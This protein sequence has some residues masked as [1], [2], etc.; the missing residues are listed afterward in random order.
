MLK[1]AVG[2]SAY[3]PAVP[4]VAQYPPGGSYKQ[5]AAIP[6]LIF[7]FF[8]ILPKAGMV[9][10]LDLSNIT[11]FSLHTLQNKN[12]FNIFSARLIIFSTHFSPHS[13]PETPHNHLI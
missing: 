10:C 6:I 4:L 8:F 9:D 13:Y 2:A 3:R 5:V 11:H 7:F 12:R 1:N